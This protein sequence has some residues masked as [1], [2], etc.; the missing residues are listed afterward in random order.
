M[1]FQCISVRVSKLELGWHS[2]LRFIEVFNVH[3]TIGL[4]L[5]VAGV[6]WYFS[7]RVPSVFLG[8]K[9]DNELGPRA[10]QLWRLKQDVV[11]VRRPRK[12]QRRCP[13]CTVVAD[14]CDISDVDAS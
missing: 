1:V 9:G 7:S 4:S 11:Q 8:G 6:S 3:M 13:S 12:M 14:R 2:I 10:E 5:V